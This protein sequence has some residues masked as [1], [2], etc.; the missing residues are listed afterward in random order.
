MIF[1]PNGFAIVH[2]V[3]LSGD[4][5]RESVDVFGGIQ[6]TFPSFDLLAIGTELFNQ[7]T[8]V[9]HVALVIVHDVESGFIDL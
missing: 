2:E 5:I 9:E 3:T 1:V 7:M 6:T 8:C 4:V